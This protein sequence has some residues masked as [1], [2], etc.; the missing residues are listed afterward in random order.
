MST[1]IELATGSNDTTSFGSGVNKALAVEAR[2]V[3]EVKESVANMR[4]FAARLEA[5][6]NAQLEM[7]KYSGTT[8]SNGGDLEDGT[9][10]TWTVVDNQ[11]LLTFNSPYSVSVGFKLTPK[12]LRQARQNPMAFMERYRRK[13]A[14]DLARKEDTYIAS[15]LANGTNVV[16]GGTATSDATLNT[17]S[18]M[19]IELFETMVDDM[20][21]REYEPTDFIGTSKIVGQLRR[22]ARLLNSSD[23]SVA[24]KED[25]ST[26][27]SIGDVMIHEVKGTTIIPNYAI[28]VGSG[29]T[30]FM[31]DRSSCFGIVDF[32]KREGASPVTISVGKPD[33]TLAGANYHRILGQQEMQCQVLDQNALV[34]ARVSRV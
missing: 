16:Y 15:V 4:K 21:E 25:G 34:V 23:F 3:F 5:T 26:V 7:E 1:I 18:V 22:D 12:L 2:Q 27:T 6:S 31:I 10:A 13:I 14:F 8:L 32:L 28:A 29:T 11:S 9:D 33:P 30:G 20:K 19:D 17:G 24:I